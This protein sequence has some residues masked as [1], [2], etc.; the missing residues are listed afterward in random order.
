MKNL[1][2]TRDVQDN[3]NQK[4]DLFEWEQHCGACDNFA[5]E[6]RCPFYNLV[7]NA[8]DT[9]WKDIGCNNFWD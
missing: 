1:I 5:D 9:Y 3:I 6:E 8:P 4:F 2:N 7:K